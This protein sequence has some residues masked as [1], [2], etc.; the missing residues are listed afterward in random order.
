M[1]CPLRIANPHLTD[2]SHRCALY[3]GKGKEDHRCLFVETLE[4]IKE[5]ANAFISSEKKKS[6][7]FKK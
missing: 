7:N 3:T 6:Y 5:A 2:C 4:A 1:K